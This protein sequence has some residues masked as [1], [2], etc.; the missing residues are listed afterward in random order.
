MNLTSMIRGARILGIPVLWTEQAPEKIGKTIPEIKKLL[1]NSQ[2]IAK[3][4]FSCCGDALFMQALAGFSARQVLLVGI[5]THVCVYQTA[6]DLV[7]F[8]YEVQVVSDAV[9][10]R[11]KKNKEIGFER[12]R[13]AGASL[14]STETA[15]CELIRVAEGDHFKK[16]LELI[17]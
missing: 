17:K 15:L 10:S 3:I 1:D 13:A 7:H 16:I 5:E 2:P 11:T 9:S 8:G 6:M 12:I 14:T 4:S